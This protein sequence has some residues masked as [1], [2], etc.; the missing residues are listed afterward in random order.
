[1][2]KNIALVLV[3]FNR[4]ELLYEMLNSLVRLEVKP[5]HIFII[6]NNSNDGTNELVRNFIRLTKEY[7]NITYHNTGENLG[8]A[9]GFS[10]GSKLAY[11]EGYKWIWLADDDVIFD[12]KCLKQLL[13]YSQM[14]DIIQ[15]MRI[16]LDGSCAE[17]SGVD[18]EINN[19]FRLNPKK[20]K[21][22]DISDEVWDNI[23]IRTIPFEGPLIHRRVFENIGF[24]NPDFFIFYDD[25]DFALRA[26]HAGFKIC[27]V[28]SAIVVRKIKFIQSKALM[29]WKG[30]FM[31]RNFFKVQLDY[32]KRP[33]GIIRVLMIFILISIFSIFSGKA[34]F[35]VTL[36]RALKDALDKKFPL[37]QRYK[38]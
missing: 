15:P 18:Y 17:I 31:Y 34:R 10:L 24:P 22:T 11:N 27:C 14:A 2:N 16:D 4:K 9:G 33:I 23:E 30:Y 3:T 35:S 12:K 36:F 25:L 28:K 8:G 29:S 19:V 20:I 6:D 13:H 5:D 38:P 26:Y 37:D 32:A 21:V 7:L 1:M